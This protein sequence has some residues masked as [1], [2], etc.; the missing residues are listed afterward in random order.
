MPSG[1]DGGIGRPVNLGQGDQHGGFHRAKPAARSRP[2]RQ[3]LEFQRMGRDIGHVQRRQ[4]GHRRRAVVIGRSADQA[5]SGQRNQRVDRRPLR[6][7]KES[8]DGRTSVQPAGKGGH[9]GQPLRLEGGDHGIVMGAVIRQNIG[10]QHQQPHGGAGA[11]R[12]RQVGQPRGDPSGQPRMIQA[13]IRVIDGCLGR[14]L[15]PAAARGIARHQ[16]AQHLF[17]IVVRPA[18]PV[19]HRQK[20]GPQVLRLAGQEAQDLRQAAQHFHLLFARGRRWPLRPAQAF[21]QLHRRR[22]GL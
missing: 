7:L 3:R 12:A 13:H 18:Q 5:E 15:G 17:D 8:L 9:H 4:S 16:K 2:L 21:E 11:R 14:G 6:T 22:G 20:P 10:P 1:K 19:L